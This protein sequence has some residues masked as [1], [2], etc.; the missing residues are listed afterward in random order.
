MKCVGGFVD[1]LQFFVMSEVAQNLFHENSVVFMK[2]R[3]ETLTMW[4]SIPCGR[5]LSQR[6]SAAALLNGGLGTH[7][8]LDGGPSEATLS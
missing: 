1:L 7:A 6:E 8:L 3:T 2:V 5:R 4:V